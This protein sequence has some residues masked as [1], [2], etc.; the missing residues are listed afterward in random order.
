MVNNREG[1]SDSLGRRLRG[2]VDGCDPSIAFEEKGMVREERGGVAIWTHAEEDKI[3][4]RKAG[5]VF[6]GELANELFFVGIGKLV[7]IVKK[8]YVDGVD[9]LWG[10]GDMGEESVGAGVVI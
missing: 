10:D 1:K 4:D 2:V 6:H 3:E 9:V 7:E 5:R 8:G